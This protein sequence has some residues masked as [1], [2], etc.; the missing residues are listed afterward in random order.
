MTQQVRPWPIFRSLAGYSFSSIGGDLVAGLT[1]AAVAVP[2]QMATAR[3]GGFG[4]E[5]GFYAFIAGSLGFAA[6][7]ANRF[8]SAGAD[9][10]ITPIFAGG[11]AALGAAQAGGNPEMAALLALLVGIVV[12]LGGA[13]RLGWIA[14]LLSVPVTTGFL[15]GIAV[16]ILVSQ[17]PGL[18]GIPAPHG[19]LPRQVGSILS[20]LAGTNPYSL[21]LGLMVFAFT[22]GSERISAKIPGALIGLA[23]ATGAT[24]LMGLED[25]G[26][27][28]LGT[29]Q[30]GLPQIGI[31]AGDAAEI[32]PMLPLALIVALVVMVQTA[33][34]SRAFP[35]AKGEPPDINR[36]FI[37]VGAGSILAGIVGS[38]PVNASPPRTAIVSETGG[39]S[40]LAGIAA[41]LIVFALAVFG[42]SLLAHVPHAAL[43]GILLFVAQR[44]VRVQVMAE[45]LRRTPAEFALILATTAAMVALPIEIGVAVGIV[46]SL[47]HGMW[48]TTR[49]RI[50]ELERVPG[51]SIWW[52]P[53][54]AFHGEAVRGVIVAAF[55][56]PLSFLNAYEFEHGFRRLVDRRKGEITLVVLEASNIVEIDYTAAK[57]ME[58]LIDHCRSAGVAFAVSRLESVRSQL[59]FK[60]FGLI[61]L[62]G[63]DRLFHSVEEAVRALSGNSP[64][65]A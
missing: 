8:L 48:T 13:F 2:E 30:G 61:E 44:I 64:S 49:A 9:S 58:T 20:S 15:A 10:T 7:G 39:R 59:A 47:M 45:I 37:G 6:F 63:P 32:L 24:V 36:D 46:L 41:A 27:S 1:L 52:P 62:L 29:L 42:A 55:Q 28:V 3:L 40:Q 34:T 65:P 16:H 43:A 4:P 26:V 56:A 23:I 5:V 25:R 38:F 31:P 14:D 21:I 19:S 57:V 11:L 22:V 17:L 60:R 12:A 33:A 35:N 18:L 51:T 53:G 50:I 54:P